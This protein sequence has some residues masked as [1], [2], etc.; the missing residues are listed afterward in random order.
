MAKT[1]LE[2]AEA[3]QWA[4]KVQRL[5]AYNTIAHN[6]IKRLLGVVKDLREELATCRELR[7]Y[8]RTE[9]AKLHDSNKGG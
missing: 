3:Q 6:E 2:R 8:D 7:E 5:E 1:A 4:D 9:I